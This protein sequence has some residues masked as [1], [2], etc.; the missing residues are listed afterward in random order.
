MYPSK[1]L[2]LGCLIL[3]LVILFGG[4]SGKQASPAEALDAICATEKPLPA[5][6]VYLRSAPTDSGSHL[7]DALIATVYGN[8]ILP[9]ALDGVR[10]AACFFSYTQP[11]ELAVFLCKS[12]NSTDAVAKMCLRRIDSLKAQWANNDSALPY[13][14][15]ACVTVRGRWVILCVSSDPSAALRAFRRTA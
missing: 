4:C 11:C 1:N 2:S 13:L 3:V 9:P 7:S 5:G 15:N 6:K 8:G 10:D 12:N 14:E